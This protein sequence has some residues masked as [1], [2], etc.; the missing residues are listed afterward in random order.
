MIGQLPNVKQVELRADSYGLIYATMSGFDPVE[1][2]VNL[3]SVLT[4]SQEWTKALVVVVSNA[5]RF[6]GH[7]RP[8]RPTHRT[9]PKIIDSDR[10]HLDLRGLVLLEFG[11]GPTYFLFYG[12]VG[13]S[14][15]VGGELCLG[16]R[17]G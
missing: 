7:R 9:R 15:Q 17:G 3:A 12:F 13:L 1:F 10:L 8:H 2:G 5:A 14:G 11:E 6:S 16:V 4:L